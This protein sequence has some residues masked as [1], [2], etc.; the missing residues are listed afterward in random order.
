MYL[1]STR[2]PIELPKEDFLFINSMEEE[3]KETN[4][5]LEMLKL[6]MNRYQA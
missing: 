3:I 2:K 6:V 5:K 4:E 1:E